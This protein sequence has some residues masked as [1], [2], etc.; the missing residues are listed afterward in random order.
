MTGAH[1]RCAIKVR[2]RRWC[3]RALKGLIYG[4]LRVAARRII[5]IGGKHNR[6]KHICS[7][8]RA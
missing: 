7:E 5:G 6:S 8:E 3:G 4:E 1:L 2:T